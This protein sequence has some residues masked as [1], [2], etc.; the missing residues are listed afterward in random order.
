MNFRTLASAVNFRSQLAN[1]A[2]LTFGGKRD[3]Y[4]AFGYKRDL[5]PQD[6]RSR[7]ERNEVA[8][9][10]V[11]AFPDACWR[12]GAEVIEDDDPSTVTE[13]E[14]AVITLDNRLKLW[15]A[16]HRTDKLSGIGRYAIL[17]LMAPGNLED[18][19]ERCNPDELMGLQP[20]AEDEAKV[21][22]WDVD[23]KS[24][25]F[26]KP[27]YYALNRN[28]SGS[29]AI[30][31]VNVS[32]RVHYSR[33]LHVSD[34][35]LDDSVF[36]TPRLR[37]IWNRLDDLEK[38][39]GGGS[40]AFYRRADPGTMFSL[41]PTLEFDPDDQKKLKKKIDDFE[42]GFKRTLFARGLDMKVQNSDVA[43]FKTQ[44][45]SIMSLISAGTG[46]PQRVLMG[47]EQGKLAAKQDRAS[48]DNK[49]TDR[50]NDYC[51]PMVAR[52]FFD[53]LITL[54]VLPTP[55]N[56][57]EVKFTSIKTMDDEQRAR[58]AGQ[59]ASLNK[60]GGEIV[61]TTDEIRGVLGLAPMADVAPELVGQRIAPVGA[62]GAPGTAEPS[63]NGRAAA[64][65][66]AEV[67]PVCHGSKLNPELCM[68]D[69]EGQLPCRNCGGTGAV[70][71][72]AKGGAPYK[73]VQEAADRFRPRSKAD[74][75]R[76]LRRRGADGRREDAARV[77]RGPR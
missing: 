36:G 6:Y 72:S 47:S 41:D 46:I 57:Y 62:P 11:D 64:R 15:D 7:Y 42:H 12:G 8:A 51:G 59:H 25:R 68:S 71:R 75:L 50:Q 33:V 69:P 48:F 74:R 1:L 20:Y 9:G 2:S 58:I 29:S 67:C 70:L 19:L 32:R 18:P 10:V 27:R 77:D 65:R 26:G 34:G 45:E 13:F 63:G 61:V 30:N 49:V 60:P 21:Q 52:P 56:G 22:E 43:D 73:H 23:R 38:V 24:P 28:T 76:G 54:G 4:R 31:S 3:L 37:R 53:G 55:A 5:L 39:V 16:L 66:Q 14:Q 35:L 17:V 44:I 40:E